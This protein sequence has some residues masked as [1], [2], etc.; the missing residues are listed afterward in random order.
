LVLDP[1][2]GAGTTAVAAL[3]NSRRAAGAELQEE[4]VKIIRERVRLL[5]LG[6]LAYRPRTKPIYEPMPNTKLTTLPKS[7]LGIN[8]RQIS[9]NGAK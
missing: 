6:S 2:L 3:K 9:L 5:E 1:F 8:G 4:Y 7:F